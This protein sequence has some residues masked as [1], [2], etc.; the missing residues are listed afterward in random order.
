VIRADNE[1]CEIPTV[2]ADRHLRLHDQTDF[3]SASGHR[4]RKDKPSITV[5]HLDSKKVDKGTLDLENDLY[6]VPSIQIPTRGICSPDT[7]LMT[8]VPAS[9]S[10]G[11]TALGEAPST[12]H[13][14]RQGHRTV[15]FRLGEFLEPGCLY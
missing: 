10:I 15:T 14:L 4:F 12:S 13:C 6:P 7:P 1:P 5:A 8:G 3:L 2:A 11:H 9:K